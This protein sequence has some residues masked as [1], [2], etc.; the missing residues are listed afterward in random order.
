MFEKTQ[1]T[2]EQ[3]LADGLL[4]EPCPNF[5]PGLYV[6]N[7]LHCRAEQEAFILGDIPI[8][9]VLR[10][11]LTQ[12]IV[13]TKEQLAINPHCDRVEVENTCLGTVVVRPNEKGGMTVMHLEEF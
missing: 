11:V 1:F 9:L 2:D 4:H 5:W 13:A 8:Y 7:T 6:T 12:A 3:L 10:E